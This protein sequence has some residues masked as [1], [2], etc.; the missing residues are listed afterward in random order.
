MTHPSDSLA[1]RLAEPLI[2]A[3]A[4]RVLGVE[5]A[6]RSLRLEN[7]AR[8]DVDGVAPDESVLVEVFARRG[9]LKTGQAHKVANDA[10]KLITLGRLRPA[11]RLVIALGDT[12]AASSITGR[13]WLAEALQT[14]GVEVLVVPVDADTSA[15]L[16]AAQATQKMVNPPLS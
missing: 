8:T 10:L 5:L 14:W 16:D 15:R 6:S 11:S 7:G 3:G 9:R 4:S 12:V 1:Q 2:L 13:S